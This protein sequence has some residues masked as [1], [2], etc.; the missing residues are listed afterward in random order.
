MKRGLN[1]LP[2]L[3]VSLSPGLLSGCTR[4][5][6]AVDE[7]L[8]ATA[9]PAVQVVQPVKKTLRRAIDQ[10]G[11]IEAFEETPIHVKIAGY[12]RKL[13]VDIGDKVRAGALLA[14]LSVPE[15]E[16]EVKQKEALVDQAKAEVVQAEEAVKVGD[17]S[18]A[19]AETVVIEMAAGRTRAR[20]HHERFLS[21]H[22]RIHDLVQRK[23]IDQQVRDETL[24]QLKSAEAT[25]DEVEAKVR[26]AQAAR[27]ES[28]ARLAKLRAD[29]QAAQAKLKVA[30]AERQRVAALFDYTQLRSPFAGVITRRTI[31]T[32]QFLQPPNG[33]KAE[34]L[35]VVVQADPVRIFVDVPESDAVRAQP[36]A[37]A[38]VRIQGLQDEEFHGKVT[39]VAWALQRQ[40]R[41]LRTE[42]DLPNPHRK[43]RPGMYAH[44]RIAIEHPETWTLPAASLVAHDG[45]DYCFIAENGQA[46]RVAVRVGS[47]EGDAVEVLKKQRATARPGEESWLDF[48]GLEAVILSNPRALADGQPIGPT[49]PAK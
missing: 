8:A 16:Q 35:F 25:R 34:P 31:N 33:A 22:Q 7:P 19:T 17:A 28:Q 41:T 24:N 6:E 45:K 23:V 49:S 48:S 15:L 39:R 29:V 13:H 44:A 40:E 36:G 46:K 9:P 21:E 1:L 12:V 10:P 18:L 26:S 14:E 38:R 3:L 43:L 2:C 32:G 42:I 5:A 30:Q 4:R 20:A 37:A 47:Q 27:T 11:Y